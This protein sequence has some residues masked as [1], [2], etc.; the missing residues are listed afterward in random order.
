MHTYL[1]YY[2]ALS[3][4]PYGDS[5]LS[6]G[7]SGTCRAVYQHVLLLMPLQVRA[8]RRRQL[9]SPSALVHMPSLLVTRVS[10]AAVTYSPNDSGLDVPANSI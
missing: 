5:I 9:L 3:H 4:C 1:L 10:V 7:V 2:F 8:Y 6:S